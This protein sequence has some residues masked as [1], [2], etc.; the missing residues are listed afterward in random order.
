MKL[1]TFS[2]GYA[3]AVKDTLNAQQ[4]KDTERIHGELI[5]VRLNEPSRRGVVPVYDP[6]EIRRNHYRARSYVKS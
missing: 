4:L 2:D 3:V 1:Y 5:Q 6:I